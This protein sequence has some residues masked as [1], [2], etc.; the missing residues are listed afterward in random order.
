MPYA[1]IMAEYFFYGTLMDPEVAREIL[2]RPLSGCSPAQGILPGYKRVCVEGASYPAI[3]LD[4]D[5]HVD[6]L[7]VSRISELEAFRLKRYEGSDYDMLSLG[8]QVLDSVIENVRVF[9]P[10]ETLKLTDTPWDFKRWQSEDK[11]RF[12]KAIQ[13]NTLV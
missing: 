4:P 11:K 5:H 10:K 2:G 9:T 6:G 3:K 8:I 1:R 12:L 13:R 7:V